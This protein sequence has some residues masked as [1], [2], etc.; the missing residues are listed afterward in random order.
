[1]KHKDFGL[2]QERDT[3]IN[4]S[5]LKSLVMTYSNDAELGAFVRS[6]YFSEHR[7]Q[8]SITEGTV[9]T[10]LD[11][12]MEEAHNILEDE[13]RFPGTKSKDYTVFKTT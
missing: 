7:A 12:Q 9:V 13:N 8:Q 5:K 11:S 2:K 6:L 4:Y 1:M 3:M 10:D